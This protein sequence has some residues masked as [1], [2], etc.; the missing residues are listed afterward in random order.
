MPRTNR[1]FFGERTDRPPESS[2]PIVCVFVSSP[3]TTQGDLANRGQLYTPYVLELLSLCKIKSSAAV[4]LVCLRLDPHGPWSKA[5]LTPAHFFIHKFVWSPTTPSRDHERSLDTSSN[6]AVSGIYGL[7]S[8]PVFF[9]SPGI[10]GI[11]QQTYSGVKQAL[12]FWSMSHYQIIKLPPLCCHGILTV[13]QEV[14]LI[15]GPIPESN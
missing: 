3:P 15:S 8:I 10:H 6:P 13:L 12:G 11:Y 9:W 5:W 7:C 2:R 1:V 4:V 14:D